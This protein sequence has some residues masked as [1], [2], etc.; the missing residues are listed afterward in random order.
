MDRMRFDALT[1]SL[2]AAGSRRGVLGL[3]FS[4]AVLGTALEAEGKNKKK[5]RRRRRRNNQPETCFGTEDCAFP[6]DGQS[7]RDCDLA[8][9]GIPT[10]DGCDFRNADLA[11]TDLSEGSFQGVSF[12]ESNLRG[13]FLDFSDVSGASF[14][15]ACLVGADF[16]GANVDG[17][18]FRGAIFCNTFLTDGSIDDSGC[19][20]TDDCCPP[21]LFIDDACGDGIFGECC[22]SDC[23]N[24]TCQAECFKDTDCPSGNICC[25]NQCFEGDC[26]EDFDC[27]SAGNVC[28]ALHCQCGQL[29]VCDFPT[30][31]CC[32]IE[33][34][35]DFHCVDTQE[36]NDNCGSCNFACLDDA[37]CVDG[38]C[39][40]D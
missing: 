39:E 11:E 25:G 36:D 27:G 15:D 18:D 22:N 2:A 21:C 8:K 23:I 40:V 38:Q 32:Q 34:T 29:P 4:G 12:R 35:D 13:A 26:C 20:D 37:F 28:V 7:F 5:R 19:G 10:C 33:D 3:I 31:I 24:G 14:R 6:S 30:P 16:F 17:A 9:T 1:R